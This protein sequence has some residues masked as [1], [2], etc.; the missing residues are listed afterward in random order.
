MRTK[1]D[2]TPLDVT[3]QPA[4]AL[5]RSESVAGTKPS[6]RP[7][8]SR[9]DPPPSLPAPKQQRGTPG[10]RSG[11]RPRPYDGPK[12]RTRDKPTPTPLFLTVGTKTRF[13]VW[14]RAKRVL[15]RRARGSLAHAR[16]GKG[17]INSVSPCRGQN[18]RVPLPAS[19]VARCI[20]SE[21]PQTLLPPP[22]SAQIN[23]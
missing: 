8:R 4:A 22:M 5:E 16:G 20:S 3:A 2:P 23:P 18:R 6:H 7:A 12:D 10:W 13:G 14:A 19:A 11:F 1:A 17:A 9:H 15:G 21:F